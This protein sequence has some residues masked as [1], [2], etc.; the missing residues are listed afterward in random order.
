[1]ALI[2]HGNSCPSCTSNISV[3][4]VFSYPGQVEYNTV[5]VRLTTGSSFD[6]RPVKGFS[7]VSAK[8]V[9]KGWPD[10][11]QPAGPP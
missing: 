11:D 2:A 10:Q 1:M 3:P 9:E 5:A 8:A 6:P 7:K 4:D